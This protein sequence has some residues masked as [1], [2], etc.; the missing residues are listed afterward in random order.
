MNFKK[1]F[2][3]LE[4]DKEEFHGSE[5]SK[6]IWA[7]QPNNSQQIDFW[8]RHN[9]RKFFKLELKKDKFIHFTLKE[10][11]E[12]IIN[13]N[14]LGYGNAGVFA[15]SC[16]YGKWVPQVQ[17]DHII[18]IYKASNIN[19]LIHPKDFEKPKFKNLTTKGFTKANMTEAISA[20][21]FTT[22]DMPQ[23]GTVE[24]VYWDNPISLISPKVIET[25]TAINI[26][27]NTPYDIDQNTNVHYY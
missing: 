3:N 4:F 18:S 22:T 24:E 17:F 1:W 25:R 19:K 13:E 21:M 8:K 16:T 23:H 15:I 27:K 14:K 2:E 12:K 20:I 9:T 26:L 6:N 10:N 7:K 5:F 11:I